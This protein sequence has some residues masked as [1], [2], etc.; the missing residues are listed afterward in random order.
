MK[1]TPVKTHAIKD[2]KDSIFTILDKYIPTLEERTVVAITSKIVSICEGSTVPVGNTTKEKLIEQEADLYLPLGFNKYGS[3]FTIKNS[4][5]ISSAGIDLSNGNGNYVLWPR[6]LQKSANDIR[7][8]LS[9]AHGVKYVG[10]VIVDSKSL[11]LR[12]GVVG[13]CLAHSGF[14][15]LNDYRG[16]KDLFNYSMRMTQS[17]IAESLAACANLAMGE[18]GE[19]MPIALIQ[20]VPRVH[21][22][23]RNPTRK[24][25]ENMIIPFA[26][27]LYYPIISLAPWIKGGGG[28]E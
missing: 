13:T 11:P 21:F 17:N 4:T 27:D 12:W 19:S 18:G 20:D 10:V 3:H 26:D 5:M 2:S 24:E 9:K 23:S 16:T 7:T 22:Q 1:I 15:T 28:R 25:L 14:Q 6:D 8:H